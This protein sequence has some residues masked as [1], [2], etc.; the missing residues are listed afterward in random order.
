[1][2]SII[3]TETIQIKMKSVAVVSCPNNF[4]RCSLIQSVDE[5]HPEMQVHL[6]LVQVPLPWQSLLIIHLNSR[7]EYILTLFAYSEDI[8]RIYLNNPPS[9]PN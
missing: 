9:S 3:N 5:S 1:M 7:K 2:K 8:V 6:L 4:I